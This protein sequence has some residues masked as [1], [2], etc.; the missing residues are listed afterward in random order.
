MAIAMFDSDMRYLAASAR[1]RDAFGLADG[2]LVGR[3]H[4]ELLPDWPLPWP[5]YHRKCLSGIPMAREEDS[6]L[7]PDGELDWL[8]WSMQPWRDDQGEIAGSV[9]FAELVTGRKRAAEEERRLMGERASRGRIADILESI[10]DAFFAV[11][12]DWRFTFV[13]RA[14]ERV[15]LR[16]QQDLIGR[17]VWHEFPEAAAHPI[18]TA[19]ARAFEDQVPLASEEFYPPAGRWFEVRAYPSRDALSIYFRD[20]TKRREAAETEARL[21]ES[22]RRSEQM[23]AMG[24]LVA[25]V[26]HQ[27][28]NPLFGITLALHGLQKKLEG[29]EDLARFF[30]TLEEQVTRLNA[31]MQDLLDY[32]KPAPPDNR[33]GSIREV[34]EAAVAS[35]GP[36]AEAARVALVLE[37]AELPPVLLD[38]QR[39]PH[40]FQN[41]IDNAIQHSPPGGV[42][43]ISARE[44]NHL[45]AHR[46]RCEVADQGPG[47]APED[48][49]RVFE[50]FYS[51][52]EG[53]T[54]LGLAIVQ[55]IVEEHGGRVWAGNYPGGGL[56]TVE[57]PRMES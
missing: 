53:G 16:S 13:N 17:Q 55:R 41:L 20:I 11:D 46:I 18:R 37:L 57:L 29:R 24:S 33:P 47:F 19:L 8:R 31:A 50:P 56:V 23:S 35:L 27:V 42:V 45:A 21:R 49:T 44:T 15:L 3:T 32:G 4:Q 43:R 7:R 54:G 38:P 48:V 22:L 5:E 12:R 40:V 52:R 14:A 51:R 28:R 25:G 10:S 9:M 30:T 1:W 34:I 39:L 2:A 6:L 36:H 26:A